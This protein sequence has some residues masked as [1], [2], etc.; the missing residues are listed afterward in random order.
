MKPTL[1]VHGWVLAALQAGETGSIQDLSNISV[2]RSFLGDR[3]QLF[4]SV[5]TLLHIL[6]AS[7]EHLKY[8]SE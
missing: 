7:C 8:H 3:P 1:Q 2:L 4:S 5:H 6:H